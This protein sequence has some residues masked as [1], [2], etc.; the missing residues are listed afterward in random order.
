MRCGEVVHILAFALAQ[1][2][3]TEIV[4]SRCMRTPPLPHELLI[5]RMTTEF[6]PGRGY[7]RHE[8]VFSAHDSLPG[9]CQD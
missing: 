6:V 2:S 1:N 5:C 3:G 4:L 7:A 8:A 9:R